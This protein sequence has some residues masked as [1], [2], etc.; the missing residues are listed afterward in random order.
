LALFATLVQPVPWTR[1]GA[2]ED[3]PQVTAGAGP[4]DRP[5]PRS[6]RPDGAVPPEQEPPPV[7]SGVGALGPPEQLPAD[8]WAQ[9][10]K[11]GQPAS[12]D[13][14]DEVFTDVQ[15]RPGFVLGDTSLVAYFDVRADGPAWSSWKARLYDAVTQTEQASVVLP[16][17]DL[18]PCSAVRQF[19]QSFGSAQGWVL[20]TTKDYFITVAAVLDGSGGE[21]VSAPSTVA[22]PR[23]TIVPPPIPAAQASG[24][25]CGTALGMTAARQAL[26][27]DGVNTATGAFTRVETDLTM[28]SFGV[29]F[30]SARVYSSANAAV[31]GPF[32]PGWAWSYGMRVTE[33]PEGAVVRADDGAEVLY[34]LVDGA[35]VRP[36]GVRSNLRRAGAG[37]ELV[38]VSQLVYGFD[39]Q[40]RLA[41]IR[42][43]RGVGTTLAYTAT[44]IT[45]TDPSGRAVAVHISGGLIR[46]ILLPDQ[47]K[48][49]YEYDTAGRLATYKDPRAR[50][51]RYRY[52][53]ANR[54]T[55]LEDPQPLRVVLARNEYDG[56]GRMARQIDAMGNATRFEWDATHEEA[57]TT[58]ADNVVVRDG[59]RGNV[60]IYSR[61]GTGDT[62]N[63]RYD[64]SL[65]RN[66]VVDGNQ[67]Q[68]EAQFDAHGNPTVRTAPQGFDERTRYDERNNP[69]EFVDANGNK[70]TNTYNE[71]NELVSSRDAEGHTITYGYDARGL[72]TTRTDQ[73]G[74]VTRYEY[75]A[76]GQPNSGLLTAVISPEGRR[77]ELRY[78]ATGRQIATI[79]PRGTVAGA[80]ASAFTTS[81][82]FDEQ[83]RVLT[84]SEP[85][86]EHPWR[87]AYDEVG[88]VSSRV[89]PTSAE[90]R[91]T[92]LDN[93][94]LAAITDP[95]KTT[96]IT[97]TSA[98]RRASVRLEMGGQG[99]DIVTTYRYNVKGLLH[100]VVSPRGNVP[101]ANPAEFTTTYRYDANDNLVRISRPYPGGIVVHKDIKVD[102]LDRTTAT[103]DEFNKPSTFGRSNTGQVT[104]TTDTL[105]RT[106]SMDYDHNGRQT[107]ITNAGGN[108]SRF[109]YDEAGN[110]IRSTTATGGVTR[111]TYSDD[112]LMSSVTEPRGNAAGADPEQFTAH[113]EYDQAGNRTRVVDPLD[114]ATV[115]AF[116]ANNR[117]TSATDARNHT[118]NYTYREDNQ[119]ET[120]HAPDAVFH[121]EAPQ[122]DATVYSYHEDGL[123]AAVR[124]PNQH[125]TYFDYDRAGRLTSSLDP[126]NR[127]TELTYDTANNLLTAFTRR[128]NESPSDAER[129]ARTIV[130]TYDIVN[131]RETRTLGTGGPVYRWGYDAK[132]RITSYGDPTGRRQVSYDDED[133]ITRVVREEA[134]R[135]ETFGY[136]YDSR[137][138]ITTRDY[139]DGTHVTAGY[140]ADSRMTS[141]T[142]AGPALGGQTAT[143]GFG[144]DIAGQRTSTTLPA[145]TGLIEQRAYDNAGRLTGI[146]TT[147]ADGSTPPPGVQDPISAF[148]LDLDEVGNPTRVITTRGGV[149]ESVAYAYDPTDRVAS[150]CYA[151]TTCTPGA[152]AAGRIDY[153]YDLVGNRTSQTRTG[154][155]GSDT[156]TY[157][158]DTANQLTS[159]TVV[160]GPTT[161]TTEYGYDLLGNQTRAGTD[162]FE[163][164]LDHTLA[165]ANAGGHTTTYGYDAAGLRLTATAGEGE[166]ATTQ[167]WSW[168]VNGTLPQIA[169]DTVVNAAGNTVERRG[170]TYGPDDEPLALLDS[171][172]GAHPYTHD[173][174]GGIANMLSPGGQP[175]AGYDY[176]PYGNPRTGDTLQPGAG[177]A[178]Q[179]AAG[180]ANPLKFTGAYQDSTTGE[181]NYYLRARNY[182]PGTG[183]FTATDPM[184]QPGPAASAYIYADNNPLAYTDPTGAM[185]EPDGGSSGGTGAPLETG[186]TENDGPSPEDLAKAQQLQNKSV[187]DVILEAGGQILMEILGINDLMNCLKGDIGACVMLVVGS[188][189]WGKIFKAKKIAEA[190]FKAGKAVLAFFEELKWAKAIIR[191]AEKAAEAAKAAAAAAAKAAAE[192]AA[193]ARAL[194]EQ[195]ARKAAAEAQAR[196]KALAAK[197]KAATKK[198]ANKADDC[199]HSFVAGTRVLLA[200]GTTKPIEQIKPG[201][202]V[203]ST[204]TATDKTE[205]HQ[206]T[207]TIRTDH[208]KTYT[209]ITIRDNDGQQH[210]ITATDNHPFWSVTR[211]RWVNA[212]DLEPGELL[213][214]SAGTYVQIKTVK[215]HRNEQRT[216]DLTIDSIHTYYVQAGRTSI[217]VHNCSGPNCTC[218]AGAATSVAG[219]AQEQ[220]IEAATGI[221]RNVGVGRQSIVGPD[222]GRTR[223]PDFDVNGSISARGTLLE[224]KDV[225]E[226]EYRGQI[227]D[228]ERHANDVLGVPLEIVVRPGAGTSIPSVGRLAEAIEQGRIIITPLDLL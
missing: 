119:L 37:W 74:K 113:F 20:D 139:P 199:L 178:P 75:L 13:A 124:D 221:P 146:G 104:T 25:G 114:H 9:L 202:T 224:S 182:N 4:V 48:V 215:P 116:D 158:Y 17:S 49:Q 38:T 200:D 180:P 226:L 82:T 16:R 167:R 207:H 157:Q 173:W 127:R 106:V 90:V 77:S 30:A 133:Q 208:D 170:F 22:K 96:S 176:D 87:T 52:D 115:S 89:S 50:Q 65:N 153:A 222:T 33:S 149:S 73:R 71:F 59:Y 159:Q 110:K 187:L 19:C 69:I 201:D 196:A 18:S 138:N 70:W 3:V 131:R 168:D 121:P 144:Y 11:P 213:R 35:Y 195:A 210:T 147:R 117:L 95:R 78:D 97:Y 184:P 100:E 107:G 161:M 34:R 79:D 220:A 125:V 27:G 64:A 103:T 175:E 12:Q 46:D 214:T 94:R 122:N 190:I 203:Q 172:T 44:G 81:Y 7:P 212:G 39:G 166:T 174:L 194:A 188:L 1:A 41:S 86:K 151:A 101:G 43:P 102:E 217:L 88:R 143:W 72:Q 99:P 197:A 136:E 156:T 42:T 54:L 216:Y 205:N 191:G 66:L 56:A 163:Y 58:D 47:R 118:T 129:A 109:E 10:P 60:L 169:L 62:D 15:L 193:K 209:D 55:E 228:F 141:L 219:Q 91:Y 162:T 206:V 112:G 227:R 108:T 218:R 148:Q 32:G 132:D 189:P 179:P 51:W 192:K 83:D 8:R 68:H 26:R 105:G 204:N 211:G 134:G 186:S 92:Y 53:A 21:I 123:L 198:A 23:Q 145:A 135:S 171:A 63:H 126:L 31:P 36:A 28:A 6:A 5:A 45:I 24:C 142:A 29:P 223:I 76:A 130:D 98:G 85:G 154:T 183:R 152:A 111:W 177:G 225:A 181:G 185:L 165:R 164:N 140:D 57:K 80:N 128:D 160:S 14:G 61:R 84:T 93:G 67:N 2:A 120:V 137:G 40:G 150:A 155:A